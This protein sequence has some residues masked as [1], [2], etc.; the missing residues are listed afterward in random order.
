MLALFG[1]PAKADIETLPSGTYIIPMDNTLQGNFNM[2][3]YGLAVRLLHAGVP[4]KWIINPSKGKDGVDFSA[5]ASR[6]RPSAQGATTLSFRAGPLAIYPGFETQAIP[7]INSYGN[8]V[9]IYQLD[10]AASVPVYSIFSTN[11]KLPFSIKAV[12]RVFTQRSSQKQVL[13]TIPTIRSLPMPP[14]SVP[15]AASLALPSRTPA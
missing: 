9:A 5:S 3:S 6:I 12:T 1:G 4:L 11:P 10:G 2:R 15:I 14:R 13:P 8:N 7:V